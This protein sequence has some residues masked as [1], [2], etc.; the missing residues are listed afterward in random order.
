[1]SHTATSAHYIYNFAANDGVNI[2]W[3]ET[4]ISWA[5]TTI[6]VTIDRPIHFNKYLSRA[7]MKQVI[8]VGNSNAFA[9]GPTFALHTLWRSD[10]HETVHLLTLP[11]SPNGTVPLFSE[12]FAVAHQ[13]NPTTGD[14]VPKWNGR[15]LS[16]H[17]QTFF[18]EHRFVAPQR[19]LTARAFRA[20]P[21][22]VAYPIAGAFMHYLIGR[23]GYPAVKNLLGRGGPND[24]DAT[25]RSHF[26]A[27]FGVTIDDVEHDWMATV[28]R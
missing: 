8:G 23:F 2:E 14:F 10:N 6:G 28:R 1:M 20:V 26:V 3:Q 7:H 13:V 16:Q 4:Y 12:G 9:R 24:S 17:L 22:V 15:Y 18:A 21:D 25:V 11:F 27:A 19:M 5:L